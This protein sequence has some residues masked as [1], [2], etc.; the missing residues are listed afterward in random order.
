MNSSN[1]LNFEFAIRGKYLVQENVTVLINVH[2]KDNPIHFCEALQSV[3]NQSKRPSKVLI[4]SDGELSQ[5]LL[6]VID[7]YI[8]RYGWFTFNQTKKKGT[9]SAKNCGFTLIDSPVVAYLDADDIMHPR[10]IELQTK[11]LTSQK[12]DICGTSMVEFSN[13]L[14]VMNHRKVQQDLVRRGDFYNSPLNN[15]TLMMTTEAFRTVGGYRNVY[16]QEDYDF[17]VRAVSKNLLIQ[18]MDIPLTAFRINDSFYSRRGGV[19]F[20]KSEYQIYKSRR[21]LNLFKPRE[22]LIFAIR[23]VYRLAP[24]PL[25]L[26]FY[27]L[28]SNVTHLEYQDL[29]GWE[30]VINFSSQ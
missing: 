22:F 13:N 16:C 25:R 8:I 28:T 30:E 11:F 12:L 27:K 4:V 19:K 20:I 7:S 17:A 26:L 1:Q 21:I 14:K 23:L 2:Y 24:S 18:N 29:T 9:W 10:R 3:L 15:P 6:K 5:D